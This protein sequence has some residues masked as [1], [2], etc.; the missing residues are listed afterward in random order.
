MVNRSVA[1]RY[2]RAFLE[3]AA[4]QGEVAEIDQDLEGASKAFQAEGAPLF[5]V[6]ANPIFT[7]QERQAILAEV[8][9]QLGLRPLTRSLLQLILEKGRFSLLHEIAEIYTAYADERAGRARVLVTTAEPL[10]PQLEAEVRAALEKVTGKEV[11]MDTRVDPD[12]IGG[13][14]A[15]VGDKVFDASV[16]TRLQNI[17]QRLL[18]GR[19]PAEA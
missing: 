10:T 9:P 2:A 1:R 19:A 11:I 5:A 8:L 17:K 6:L 4:E 13:M 7:L 18:G 16:H 14:V 3:L 15:R 12:L